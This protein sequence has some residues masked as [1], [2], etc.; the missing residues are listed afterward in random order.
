M[1]IDGQP[2]LLR[3]HRHDTPSGVTRTTLRALS[4]KL[5]LSE[6]DAIQLALARL[7]AQIRPAYEPDDGPLSS[8]QIA[9]VRK[10]ANPLLPTGTIVANQSLF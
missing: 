7:V 10:R 4:R 5:G 3:F 2:L 1:P 9:A 6:E 8:R